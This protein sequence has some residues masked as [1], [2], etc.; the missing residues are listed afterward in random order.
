[1]TCPPPCIRANASAIWLRFE[2]STQMKRTRFGCPGLVMPLDPS[3]LFGFRGIHSGY[4]R[5][6]VFACPREPLDLHAIE[7]GERGTA[8]DSASGAVPTA[9]PRCGSTASGAV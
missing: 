6:R 3:T 2:F 4:R 7:P 1:S 5:F 8:P 9:H